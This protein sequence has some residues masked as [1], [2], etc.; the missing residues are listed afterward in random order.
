MG[1]SETGWDVRHHSCGRF[2]SV[3]T[4]SCIFAGPVSRAFS[5]SHG[6]RVG[7]AITSAPAAASCSV[8]VAQSSTSKATRNC[9]AD[10]GSAGLH[11]VD[12]VDLGRIGQLERGPARVQDHHLGA[13]S[14][15]VLLLF[16]KS[17]LVAVEANRVVVIR[18]GHYQSQ[19]ANLLALVVETA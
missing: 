4:V 8:T 9:G 17:E 2:S 14:G 11:G 18:S 1:T 12:V 19:L 7:G 10:P 15:V 5:E 3:K 13:A 16:G 6:V